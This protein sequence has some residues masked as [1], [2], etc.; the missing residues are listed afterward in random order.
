MIEVSKFKGLTPCAAEGK[1][2]IIYIDPVIGK[3]KEQ[4]KGNN[5]VFEDSLFCSRW[6]ERLGGIEL[7]I[8]DSRHP[9]DPDLPYLL[10]NHIGY[11]KVNSS[12]T[13]TLQGTYNT[14]L[15]YLASCNLNGMS[16]K[17]VYDFTPSQAL[18]TIGSIG[19]TRQYA[20]LSYDVDGWQVPITRWQVPSGATNLSCVTVDGRY[21]Y[22]I[23]SS[24]V[25]TKLDLW[26]NNSTTQD[27]SAIVGATT[28]DG[29]YMGHNP[30]NGRFY[31]MVYS[32]TSSRRK[33]YEFAD[34]TFAST[35]HV[36][37]TP[38]NNRG[39]Y[40]YVYNNLAFICGTSGYIYKWDYISDTAPEGIVL[41]KD[42]PYSS[43][44]R[45]PTGH[46]GYSNFIICIGTDHYGN[47]LIFDMNTQQTVGFISL[48]VYEPSYR[49][50]IRYPITDNALWGIRGYSSASVGSKT[51]EFCHNN[52][53]AVYRVPN[54]APERPAGYGMTV[55]YEIQIQY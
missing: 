6:K 25:I 8:T 32:S 14:A 39:H 9:I 53:F 51:T 44:T 34:N 36:Y 23:S 20:N 29:K 11:G 15:S 31:V 27:I 13:G 42:T 2:T 18:G 26:T 38:N 43:T 30:A 4:I 52:A 49:S 12:G 5:H 40:F 54:G 3:I 10:G 7:H 41:E 50:F 24:G 28:A 35:L 48:P 1:V 55:T 46:C 21:Q 22:S 45:Y 19:L 47:G 16:W 33:L 37:D 17:Y